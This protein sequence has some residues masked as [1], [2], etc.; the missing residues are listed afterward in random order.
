V[1]LAS[2]SARDTAKLLQ[3]CVKILYDYDKKFHKFQFFLIPLK[4]ASREDLKVEMLAGGKVLK[5][6]CVYMCEHT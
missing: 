2:S 4:S 6:T 5:K 1:I 3:W